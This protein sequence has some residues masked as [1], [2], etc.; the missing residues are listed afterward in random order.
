MPVVDR[1]AQT[2]VDRLYEALRRGT[3]ADDR[4]LPRIP[5]GTAVNRVGG[6]GTWRYEVVTDPP[7]LMIKTKYAAVAGRRFWSRRV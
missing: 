6:F 4:E 3:R 7:A 5:N 2:A 1:Y